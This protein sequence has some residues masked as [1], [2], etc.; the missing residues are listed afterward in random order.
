MLLNKRQE[1]LD[2]EVF[3]IDLVLFISPGFINHV[4]A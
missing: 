4:F 2:T 1:E 3:V